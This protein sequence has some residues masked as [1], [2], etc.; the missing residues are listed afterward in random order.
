MRFI[1]VEASTEKGDKVPES[2]FTAVISAYGHSRA[3]HTI[4]VESLEALAELKSFYG[5]AISWPDA[6]AIRGREVAWKTAMQLPNGVTVEDLRAMPTLTIMDIS[7][8]Q[9]YEILEDD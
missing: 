5:V 6:S 4:E 3:I 8:T 9:L 1:V 2:H 7:P